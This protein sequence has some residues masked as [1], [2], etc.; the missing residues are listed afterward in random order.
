[1]S[2]LDRYIL[3]RF[4]VNFIILFALLFIFAIAIDLIVNLDKFIESAREIHGE[5]AGFMTVSGT[6]FALAVDFEGPRLFQFYAYL[7]GL[8]AV[9][10]MGFTLSQMHRY[11][12]LVAILASGVSL[13]RVAMPFIIAV[14][15]LALLQLL[16]QELLLPRVAPL[17]LRDY[18]DIGRRGLEKFSVDFT[19]DGAGNLLHATSFDP[20]LQRLE[21]PTFFERDERGRTSRRITATAATWSEADKAWQLADGVVMRPTADVQDRQT[22]PAQAEQLAL[23]PSSL[24]PQSLLVRHYSHFAA[25]LSMG[26]ISQMLDTPLVTDRDALLRNYYSRF[27]GVLVTLLVLGASLP[28]FLLR[29]PANMLRQAMM[30][31][32][33]AIPATV[34]ASL[35]MLVEMPRIP[36]AVGVFLPVIV[37]AF[38]AM[39][40][41]T[42]LKT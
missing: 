30:C 6:L 28:C 17:L 25:M 32:A 31:S 14:F 18:R 2:L 41:W 37:L 4:L 36:P 38:M 22:N 1:M 40:P 12:E 11:R 21:N 26:Q 20:Q 10:A 9:G 3:V 33:V 39:F 29:E 15:G 35:G 8:V 42:F 5:D 34:G 27:S 24:T 7:H 23:Y 19:V 13:H 16:N